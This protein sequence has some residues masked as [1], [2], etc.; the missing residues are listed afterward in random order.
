MRSMPWVHAVVAT[1]VGLLA[2]CGSHAGSMADGPVQTSPVEKVIPTSAD[3]DVLLVIDNEKSTQDWQTVFNN[4]LA[5][6]VDALSFPGIGMPNLHIGVVDTT[7]DI[8]VQGYGPSCPSPDPGDN[9]LLQ[10][11]A[12]IEGCTPP[13]G[14]FIS[15]IKNADGTRTT[16]YNGPGSAGDLATE[17]QCIA[18]V[19]TSGCGFVAPLEAMKRALDGSNPQNAG[20]LRADADLAI[21]IISNKDDMSAEN[22]MAFGSGLTSTFPVLADAYTCDTP[23]SST[24][25][26]TYADCTPSSQPL[27][28]PA[29]YAGFLS[30]IKD[31]SQTVVAVISG[32]PPSLT[33]NDVPPQQCTTCGPQDNEISTGPLDEPG[34]GETT[35]L[36]IQPSC[37]A[38]LDGNMSMAFP[39]IR[40]AS[41]ITDLGT[42]HGLFY[43]ACQSDYSAALEAIAGVLFNTMS[44]CLEGPINTS[45]IDPTNPGVQ[46]ACTVTDVSNPGTASETQALIPPCKM[47]DATTPE[48]DQPFPCWY[49][50]LNTAQCA[51][52][53]TGYAITVDRNNQGPPAGAVTQ[54]VCVLAE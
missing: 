23:I 32:P 49:A 28:A 1:G 22:S 20:F 7:V 5:A 51:A 37:T 45:D 43:S 29:Y 53:D 40:L 26:G 46:L 4:N 8:G 36:T 13:T 50:E 47:A 30:T 2:A 10:N 34:V 9:G 15:D 3:L 6:L 42:G 27:E 14:R 12:Q 21:I 11:T 24:A 31:P 16:D 44:S 48:G 39:A 38:T 54:V 25:P 17:L 52:P 18:E 19:G 35:P 33:T 41:F